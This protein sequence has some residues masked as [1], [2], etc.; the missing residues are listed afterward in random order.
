MF[1][2]F[3]PI[4]P[5]I[6]CKFVYLYFILWHFFFPF[7]NSNKEHLHLSVVLF[8]SSPKIIMSNTSLSIYHKVLSQVLCS[9]INTHG[10]ISLHQPSRA[11]SFNNP[12]ITYEKMD[13]FFKLYFIV[14]AITV[15]PIFSPLSPS[16][17]HPSPQTTPTLSGNPHTIVHVVGHGYKFFG[18]SISYTVLYTPMAIL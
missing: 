17:R 13:S 7:N 16:T 1:F 3:V 6:I 15:V 9:A 2:K 12:H 18:F 14:Y 8:L 5:V 10:L 4:D 11:D